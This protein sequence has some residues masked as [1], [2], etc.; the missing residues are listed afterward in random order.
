MKRKRE[1][2][3]K[4]SGIINLIVK[5]SKII[6]NHFY[7]FLLKRI[8]T[9][10]NYIAMFLRFIC[11]KN[12]AKTCG[13]NIAI[14][15]N[16]YLHNIHKLE[17]GDNVSI[18]PMCYI[19]ASGGLKIASNV[20]IAHNSTIM[21]EEHIYSNLDVNIKDQGCEYKKTIIENNVWIGA[22]CRLLAG[23]T[24]ESGSIV[25]A[26]AV[27]KGK[28]NRNTIVGGVPAKKIKERGRL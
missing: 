27:V 16:V 5:V 28:V 3:E 20:S 19:E 2:I 13:N 7:L 12:C 14:F 1:I 8:R 6:P 26:G 22:G 9:H 17:I 15:S 25:A 23:C 21:S 24:I 4:W 18:Q 10:D 11:L